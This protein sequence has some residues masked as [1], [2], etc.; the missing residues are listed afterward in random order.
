MKSVLED[1]DE[2][3][4]NNDESTSSS[5]SV[6]DRRQEIV[7]I[8]SGM[9][10]RKTQNNIKSVLDTCLLNDAEWKAY[11]DNVENEPTLNDLFSCPIPIKIS[12]Y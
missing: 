11:C 6:G 3:Q 2:P 10:N 9:Q 7:F 8:G 4:H 12:T 5:S 1:F